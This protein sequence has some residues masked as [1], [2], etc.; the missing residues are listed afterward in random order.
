MNIK[1]NVEIFGDSIL[2]GIQINPKNMRYHVDNNIDVETIEKKHSL[3]IKNFSR[4]GCTIIQGLTLIEKRLKGGDPVCDAII[5]DYGGNDC[6]FK[7]GEI[8]ECPEGEHQPNTPLDV[9]VET[10]CKIIAMLKEKGIRPI[11][12]TLPP[13]SAQRFFQWFCNGLNMENILKWLGSVEAIYRWQETYSRAVEKIA[14]ETN[15]LLVDMRGAF[16]KH[17]QIENLLCEDGAHPNTEGQKII[18]QAFLDFLENISA[19]EKLAVA[20]NGA[21]Q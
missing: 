20:S 10:Y 16:L 14:A 12:T 13:L 9:F 5:M 21:A 18:T 6:D 2:K 3:S 17:R 11:I 7:W 4:L 8:A 15:T 19:K 1:R